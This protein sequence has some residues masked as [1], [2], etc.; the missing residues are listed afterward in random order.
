M[1]DYA[2][3][4]DGRKIA[5]AERD[6]ASNRITL[7]L[8]DLASGDAGVAPIRVSASPSAVPSV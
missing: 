1:Y 7:K 8:V 5:Y 3:S 6:F 4:P 2:P